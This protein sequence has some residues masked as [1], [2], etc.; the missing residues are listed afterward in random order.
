MPKTTSRWPKRKWAPSYS[1]SG[2]RSSHVTALCGCWQQDLYHASLSG[3]LGL[4][5]PFARLSHVG[6]TI[7]GMNEHYKSHFPP[8][9][10][11]ISL[12]RFS[13]RDMNSVRCMHC[14]RHLTKDLLHTNMWTMIPQFK[15]LPGQNYEHFLPFSF[16]TGIYCDTGMVTECMGN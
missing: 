11:H 5:G 10:I 8:T 4:G 7:K 16:C 1:G 6:S 2:I 3:P 15:V 12:S 14:H 13:P 9:N